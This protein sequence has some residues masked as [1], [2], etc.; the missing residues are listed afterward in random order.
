MWKD[1]CEKPKNVK[2]FMFQVSAQQS[3][4]SGEE[5]FNYDVDRKTCSGAT[6]QPIFL[7]HPAIAQWAHEKW[8]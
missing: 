7:S 3:V 5:D 6:I 4:T 8:P 1:L 2:I